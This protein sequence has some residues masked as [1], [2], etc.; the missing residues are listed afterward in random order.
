MLT[1]FSQ[2]IPRGT[3]KGK[4]CEKQMGD[5]DFFELLCGVEVGVGGGWVFGLGQE[6]GRHSCRRIKLWK[7]GT[8]GILL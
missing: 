7:K 8:I 1:P 3:I 5:V 6:S 4:Y 2:I